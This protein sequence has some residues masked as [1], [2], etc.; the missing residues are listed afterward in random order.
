MLKGV[1]PPDERENI[2]GK[3]ARLLGLPGAVDLDEHGHDLAV[4]LCL[5]VDRLG[6]LK[7]IEG[8]DHIEQRDDVFDFVG[9]DVSD[10]MPTGTVSY[11]RYDRPCLLKIVL[12]DERDAGVDDLPDLGRGA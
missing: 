8:L 1:D 12:A 6:Q 11:L 10:E 7:R 5:S 2:V 9:L 3:Y 4:P